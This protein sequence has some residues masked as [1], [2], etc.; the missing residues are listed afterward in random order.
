MEGY[1]VKIQYKN[2]NENV[3]RSTNR[4][5]REILVIHPVDELD[6][7]AELDIVDELDVHELSTIVDIICYIF[8]MQQ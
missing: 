2:H 8:R 6:I 5:V 3:K 7:V 1:E 4:G